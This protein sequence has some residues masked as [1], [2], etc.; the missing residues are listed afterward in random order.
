MGWVLAHWSLIENAL[1]LDLIE[2]FFSLN[3]VKLSGLCQVDIRLA[4]AM[5]IVVIAGCLKEFETMELRIHL[6]I[7]FIGPREER[8]IR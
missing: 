3:C 6:V 5:A 4:S 7:C 2:T 8:V 1:Q